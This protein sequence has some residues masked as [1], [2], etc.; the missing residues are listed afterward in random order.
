MNMAKTAVSLT[1][2]DDNLLWLRGR[3]RVAAGGNLS[4]A[5]NQ[6]I[7]RARSG[8]LGLPVAARSVAGTI[9]VSPED[10]ELRSADDAVQAVFATSLA[11]PTLVR[12]TPS[13]EPLGPPK[14]VRRRGRRG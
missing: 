4:E 12:E 13:R 6:L 11:R 7:T 5:V 1:L 9:D 8:G 10:P 14:P 2:N 3:A